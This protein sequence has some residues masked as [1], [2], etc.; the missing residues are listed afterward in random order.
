MNPIE[1]KIKEAGGQILS[2]PLLHPDG[3]VNPKCEEEL[4]SAL[5][6]PDHEVMAFAKAILHGSQ[7]HRYWLIEAARAFIDN[8]EV[9][10]PR[11]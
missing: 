3:T 10:P 8:K 6:K 9:P 7:E 11:A 5:S 1:K 4:L 2:E